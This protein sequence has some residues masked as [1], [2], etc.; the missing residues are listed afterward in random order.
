MLNLLS[1]IPIDI[2]FQ[3]QIPLTITYCP[4]SSIYRRWHP[5]QGK[6]ESSQ[7]EGDG[8]EDE[9]NAKEDKG[10]IETSSDGQE[11]SDGEDWQE[12]PHTQDT[13]MGVSSLAN[14]RTQTKSQTLER[15]SSPSGKSGAQKARRRT[16]PRKTPVNHCL[17]R[18]SCQPM[19]HS[20]MGPGKKHS[21]WTHASM[22]GITTKLPMASRVG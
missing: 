6:S 3:T 17:L 14:M 13:L 10:R 22:L 19:R 12:C 1:Q 4:E 18:R 5:E 2:L 21:C 16:V 8:T 11:A 7:D 15:K 9:D 20:V